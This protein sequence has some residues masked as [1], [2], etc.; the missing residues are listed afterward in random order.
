M[1]LKKIAALCTAGMLTASALALTSCG[2]SETKK[3]DGKLTI[4]VSIVPQETFAKAICGDL[5]NVITM[6]PP[7][8]SPETYEPT[9]KEMTTFSD[10]DIYFTI[11]VPSEEKIL[12]S[13]GDVTV[14]PLYTEI[15]KTYPD[16][17]F[18]EG[19][20]DAHI[21]LS[22]KRMKLGIELM[23]QEIVKLDPDNKETYEQNAQDYIAQLD[24]VDTEIKEK[25]AG[26]EG[27]KFVVYHPAFGYFADE[28]GLE[29]FALE[30]EG[31]EAT[32][33]HLQ[34]MIDLAKNENIK[35]IFYQ[36]ETDSSQA[37]AYAEE[38][39]GKAVMLAPLSADYLN[40]LKKM[41]DAIA[42]AAKV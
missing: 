24:A 4:A 12:Q 1:N 28:Y 16:R 7:G 30:E 29:M 15:A 42:E 11:G 8:S 10:A 38:V 5:A 25:L 37:E 13:A 9:P 2:D 36:Q 41:A 39:G 3:D 22:P 40:N 33:Q 20:R 32:P 23:T 19:E 35:V 27:T 21:W 18:E 34:D 26:L 6:V 14:Y 17:T 31:K